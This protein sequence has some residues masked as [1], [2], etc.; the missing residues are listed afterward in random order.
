MKTSILLLCSM[1]LLCCKASEDDR[2]EQVVDHLVVA[3]NHHSIEDA[4]K[5]Y[6]GGRI[7][8]INDGGDSNTVYRLLTIPGGE[9]FEATDMQTAL[10]DDHA[11]ASFTLAGTLKRGDSTVGTMGMRL[12]MELE[13]VDGRWLI[14]PGNEQRET[15]F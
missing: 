12:K 9:K 6:S 7:P 5:L 3:L 15:T 14:I 4:A 1:L 11:Q 10:L 2:V 8:A 13:K